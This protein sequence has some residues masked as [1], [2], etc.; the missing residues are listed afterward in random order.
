MVAQLACLL[1][2][3]V[4][5]WGSAY[6]PTAVADSVGVG[7]QKAADIMQ[8]RAAN[9]LDRMAGKGSSDRVEGALE[10]A[11]GKAQRGIG[12]AKGELN[13]G[14]GDQLESAADRVEGAA[15]QLKGKLKRD[16]GRVK[17]KVSDLG[18]DIEEAAENAV[19][20]IKETFD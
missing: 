17:G 6:V 19:D 15:N 5:T 2:L 4:A 12:R 13:D 8:E 7:S 11:A 20:S 10:G 3:T 16:T 14:L 9:E 1:L 18:D